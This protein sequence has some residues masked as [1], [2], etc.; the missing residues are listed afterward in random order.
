[1]HICVTTVAMRE[2]IPVPTTVLV[3]VTLTMTMG[4]TQVVIALRE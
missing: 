4:F 3:T 1:M 2:V